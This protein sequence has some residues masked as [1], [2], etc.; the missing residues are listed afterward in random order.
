MATFDKVYVTEEVYREVVQNNELRHYGEQELI[1]A[2]R[3]NKMIIYKVQNNELI[4][5]M[6]G[7]LH[8]GELEVIQAARELNIS[9]V[10]IDDRSARNRAKDML[11]KPIGIIGI[12][13]LTKKLGKINQIKSYLDIL[14]Q[15]DYRISKRLYLESLKIA[16]EEKKIF[17]NKQS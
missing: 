9:R 7:R 13:Q 11:L 2:V 5:A 6:M 1:N 3:D 14:I 10:I 4:E 15:E 17:K 16:D 12:L 8:R